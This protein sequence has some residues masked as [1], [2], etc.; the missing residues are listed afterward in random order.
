MNKDAVK[1]LLFRIADDQLIIG[2]RNSE[3]T[4]IGPMLEEDIAF[5][6]MAQDKLGQSLQFYQ[7]LQEMGEEYPD[8]LAFTRNADQFRNCTFVELPVENYS[9]SLIRH[10][11]FD[12]A[13]LIRFETLSDSTVEPLA[14][15]SRKIKGEIA[16]PQSQSNLWFIEPEQLDQLGPTIGRGAVWLNDPV[17]ANEPTEGFLISGYAERSIHLA[18]DRPTTLTME[19]D[20][21]GNG[22]WEPYRTIDL[23]GYTW[24]EIDPALDAI[25]MRLSSSENLDRATAWF[26]LAGEDARVV[27]ASPE[28]FTGVARVG[29]TNNSG[30]IVR[31]QSDNKRTLHYASSSD[32]GAYYI[33]DTAMNLALKDSPE[34]V[35][36]LREHASSPDP[37]GSIQVDEASI[38]YID[39]E[40]KRFRLPMNP[41]YESR[42]IQTHGRFC[43][44][45]ATERDLF[46][47]FGTFYELPARNAAG[48]NRVRP[49]SSHTLAIQDYCSYRGLLVFSG[50]DLDAAGDNHH[51]IRSDDGK[52]GLWVGAIDDLWSL[53]K[54]VGIGGPWK[55]T[56]VQANQPSDPYLMTGYD[57]K[58]LTLKSS[59]P[60]RITAE[61]DI[62][63]M[64]D[65]KVYKRFEVKEGEAVTYQFPDAFQ[66]YWIRFRSEASASVSAILN[67]Q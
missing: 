19:I 8:T 13:E 20:R 17:K 30:G 29:S 12:H 32:G 33:L 44:E 25:W 50:V 45:V 1:D 40:G 60:T 63:G 38:V 51:I 36:W 35:A 49:I 31:A 66:A 3:W 28:K 15:L 27:G 62:S 22:Q 18:S 37:E 10:F 4:G 54:P 16:E 48:F 57:Q 43:R 41:N 9:F 42:E 47:C 39:D 11:L 53:G 21:A 26:T 52:T 24:A 58:S 67:Y 61:V 23:N 2:H 59:T 5:S 6:S 46:N 56:R 7:L 65:W 64:G 55:D 34:E 14:Q